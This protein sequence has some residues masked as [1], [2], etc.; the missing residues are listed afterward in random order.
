[1]EEWQPIG[2]LH[3]SPAPIIHSHSYEE[4]GLMFLL[5]LTV[6]IQLAHL[7]SFSGPEV[8]KW[9]MFGGQCGL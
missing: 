8:I 3:L 9:Q 2:Q 7:S 5:N 4:M 6:M 1:M